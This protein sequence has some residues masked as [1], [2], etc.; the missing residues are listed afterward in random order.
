MKYFILI[1]L[2]FLFIACGDK[3]QDN[4]A[5]KMHWDRDM[6][7]RCVMV[8][9]DRKNSVQLRGKT[10]KQ[11]HKFDDMG[12]LIIWLEENNIP[13]DNTDIW[14]TDVQSGDWIDAKTAFYTTGNTTPMAY[15]FSA[16][17]SK[18]SIDKSKDS[19]NFLEVYNQ[20]KK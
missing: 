16:Y 12:C 4:T 15:G 9:S 1:P 7:D 3:S 6:C 20:I 8:I 2:M 5:A 10:K 17:R 19:I 11:V 14:V 13:V 18:D